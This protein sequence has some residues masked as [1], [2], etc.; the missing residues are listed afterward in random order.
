MNN[1]NFITFKCLEVEQPI[2][3]FYVGTINAQDLL[4]I[5]YADVHRIE[6]RKIESFVGIERPLVQSRVNELREYVQ[7]VDATFPTSIILA[8]NSKYAK[9]DDKKG[10]MTL[11]RDKEVAQIIDG[12]HRIAGLRDFHGN[13]QLNI[14]IFVDMDLED[15]AM[16]FSTI[17]LKQTKVNKSLAYNLYEFASSRSP[18][19]TC[20]N[21]AKLLNAKKGSPFE[22]K[23]KILGT[24][25]GEPFETLTQATFVERLLP[26]VSL[27]PM[28][29]RDLL[30]RGGKKLPLIEPPE[31]DK[32]IFRNMF[33]REK[34]AEIARILYNYFGAVAKKWPGA[35]YTKEPGKILSRTTGFAA[36]MKFLRDVFIN[37]GK[38]EEII[39]MSEF[40]QIFSKIKLKESDF[41]P[42]KYNPGGMG[43]QALYKDL[44]KEWQK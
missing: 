31:T 21:I 10:I 19:K 17:N 34:D 15:Q 27:Q 24:V 35:W 38:P 44:L 18:Q 22:G 13:F 16:V 32:L 14:T 29:D 30:K 6:E 4:E 11:K 12:Q 23:I 41:T 39:S 9:Y 1:D 36:L 40:E 25:T 5:S 20:H 2:G 26:Y 7:T 33:I 28:R 43:E 37:F 3:K 8:V 42:E